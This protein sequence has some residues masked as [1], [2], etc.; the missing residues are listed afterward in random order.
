[1]TQHAISLI[2]VLTPPA[3]RWLREISKRKS[4]LPVG[5]RVVRFGGAEDGVDPSDELAAAMTAG[6]PEDSSS[7]ARFPSQPDT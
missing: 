4:D 1:M 3:N 6:S 7:A 2:D 5:V